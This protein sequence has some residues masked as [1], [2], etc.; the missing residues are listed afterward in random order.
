MS[1][2]HNFHRGKKFESGNCFNLKQ[3]EKIKPL[4]KGGKRL[5]AVD[6]SDELLFSPKHK[7]ST[8]RK[9]IKR[10]YYPKPRYQYMRGSDADCLYCFTGKAV[11]HFYSEENRKVKALLSELAALFNN[12]AKVDELE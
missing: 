4:G 7:S 11:E 5:E 3:F 8:T 1:K 9:R 2:Q 12:G 6:E 10:S